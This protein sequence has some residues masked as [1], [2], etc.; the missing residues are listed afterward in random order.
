VKGDE[1]RLRQVLINLLGNAVKFTEQGG[2]T[3]RVGHHLDKLRFEVEDTGIGIKAENLFTIFDPFRQVGEQYITTEGTGLGLSISKNLVEMMGGELRVKSVVGEG[4][5]FWFDLELPVSDTWL[6]TTEVEQTQVFGYEGPKQK[7][8]IVDDR[9][10]NR[11]V[12]VRMLAPLGFEVHEAVD[13]RDGVEQAKS[14]Q[15][16]IILMDLVMP[17]LD[18]FE[19]TRQIRQVPALESTVI[20]AISASAFGKDRRKSLDVGC[21]D[22]IAKPIHLKALLRRLQK[23]LKLTWIYESKME[24]Q[25]GKDEEPLFEFPPPEEI[26]T[27]FELAQK[28]NIRGVEKH[29]AQLE[30]TDDKFEPFVAEIRQLTQ[31]FKTKQLRELLQSYLDHQLSQDD[32]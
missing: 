2:V 18:G 3:F 15:P 31:S 19:A 1:K 28:G 7:V 6:E 5:T 11:L 27:L 16:D 26:E 21:N 4:S 12:L 23:H 13:G 29:I 22:F 20:I 10:E 8:L 30:Q 14:F 32:E 9:H 24:G 17:E 25:T